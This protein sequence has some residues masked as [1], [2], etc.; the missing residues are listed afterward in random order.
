MNRL[1]IIGLGPGDMSYLTMQ[2]LDKLQAADVVYLRTAQHPI[3]EELAAKGIN[4][5]SYDAFYDRADCFDDVYRN[6]ADDIVAKLASQNVVYAVPGNPFVAEKT[7]E[8]LKER[9]SA[10]D[11]IH[12][13]S[14]IDAVITALGIDPVKGLRI[15]DSLNLKPFR[16]LDDDVLVCIQCYNL[17]VAGQLKIWLSNIFYDEHPVL[18]VQSA[19]IKKQQRIVEMPLYELDRYQDFDH[20][21]SVVVMP[22]SQQMRHQL[23]DLMAVV[24]MLR[25]EN[26]CPW[27]REQDHQGLK[28]SVLEEAYEVAEALDNDDIFGLEEELGDLLLQ[29]VFHAQIARENGDFNMVDVADGI[30]QKLIRRH[31]HVFAD[32][33][34]ETSEQVKDNWEAIKRQENQHETVA[35]TMHKYSKGLPALFRSSKVI[36]KGIK[37]GFDW[38]NVEQAIAKIEEEIAELRAALALSDRINSEEEL[39]DI[40]FA[41]CVVAAKLG[42]QPEEALQKSTDKFIG[43]YERME[44]QLNARNL[45]VNQLDLSALIDTWRQSKQKI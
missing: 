26:G 29:V 41:S 39:G 1:T 19:G 13:A 31:P 35:D 6:I 21:T 44:K 37:A 12:G 9:C 16:Q 17:V 5:Q 34:A 32:T 33:I 11:Y 3:V 27:D 43:R 4:F 15:V 28:P 36:S 20:L 25:S 22:Q 23:A 10:I 42:I 45:A 40:L 18:V 24:D 8:L 7:V 2:A 14:F 30:S 38:E